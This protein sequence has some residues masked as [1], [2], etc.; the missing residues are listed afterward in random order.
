MNRIQIAVNNIQIAINFNVNID[1]FM[2]I[3]IML[4]AI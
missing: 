3:W 1:E 2:A 4:M